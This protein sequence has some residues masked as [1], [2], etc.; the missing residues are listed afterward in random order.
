MT[1][2][3]KIK[4]MNIDGFAEWFDNHCTHD[5]DPCISW[6][7][8]TYCKNCEPVIGTIEGYHKPMEFAWCEIYGKCRFFQEMDHTPDT[9]E[10]TKLWL[11]SEEDNE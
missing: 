6:W 8:N 2:F 3:E 11:E 5:S 4:A 9:K 1:V 10:M 7:D